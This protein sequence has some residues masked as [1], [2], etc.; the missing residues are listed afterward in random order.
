MNNY[1][2]II[3]SIS[4]IIMTAFAVT[5]ATNYPVNIDGLK[6]ADKVPLTKNALTGKLPNGLTYFI[7]E[8]TLPANR[9]HLALVV[10]AGSVLETEEQRGFAHFVEH[11]AFNDTARFPKLELI[12]YLR[13][14]G[15]RFGADANAYTSYDQTVYHFDVPVEI[16]GGVKRIPDKALAILDDWTYAVSF[17]PEDVK[18][19]SLVV[20]EEFRTGLGAMERV[21]KKLL[22]VLFSG[23]PYADRQPIGLEETVANA[24]SDQLRA[25]YDRWY[26][27]DNMALV[28][29]GDFD[30]KTLEAELVKHFNM[31]SAE[32]PVKRPRYELPPPK[33]NNFQVEILTDP[34]LA[35]SSINIYFKQKKGAKPGTIGSYYEN[36]IDNLIE[37][38]LAFR[39]EEI[40]SNPD[41]S[42]AELWGYIWNSFENSN[43]FAMGTQPKGSNY[44]N[45]LKEILLEKESMRRFGFTESELKRAKL[46][47]LSNMEKQL[48]EKDRIESRSFISGFT[49]YFVYGRDMADIE[50]EVNASNILIE[51]ITLKEISR[52][53]KNYFANNDC[54]VFLISP[55][56]EEANLPSKEK[57]KNIFLE[58][59]SAELLPRNDNILT[60]DLMDKVPAA[61]VIASET[62]DA[63]TGAYILT[64]ANGAKV[65]LKESA[66]KNNEIV[67]YAIARGGKTNAGIDAAASVSALSDMIDSSGLGP[68]SRTELISKLTGKQVFLSF[69]VSN[70]YRGFQGFSTT[71]DLKTFFEMIHLFFT[72][73]KLDERSISALL[74][75]YRANLAHQEENPERYFSNELTRIINNYNPYFM[76]LVLSDIDKISFKA[77]DDY[78]NRCV[79]PSD[80]T[81]VFTGN[82]SLDAMREFTSEYIAS[83]PVNRGR[84]SS[85][86]R[87]NNPGVSRPKA[88]KRIIKKGM[89]DRSIVYIGWFAKG[90]DAFSEKRN[91]TAAVLTE[92]LDILL[93]DEIREKLGGVYSISAGASVFSIPEGEYRLYAYFVCNPSRADELILAV[94]NSINNAAKQPLDM[95]KFKKSKEALLMEHESSLQRNMHIAQSYANSTAL[96]NT[97][98][99]RLNLR[100]DAIRAVTTQDVQALCREII[101]NGA[102]EVVLLPE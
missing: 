38:M 5:C 98:L 11:L 21:R 86:N 36:I 33:N 50:W 24:A 40:I 3:I 26:A 22:P 1:K 80:Y 27:S 69:W 6:S 2:K 85:I 77:A 57:I 84:V 95:D 91:Q 59:K 71:A 53:V 83:I 73:P 81:F 75:Q 13:S 46:S 9:A 76:P 89:D 39:F 101:A 61:G 87:W 28:F 51:K 30:G 20:L 97:P 23:S 31:P 35:Y 47:Y 14:L 17:L 62:R 74:D 16:S 65:I 68:Y 96:Y 25:F 37:T 102:V 92:Y 42:S 52:A 70:Y 19:E 58:T 49:G 88:G 41:S 43:F 45:A 48:S 82:L 4:F 99:N 29:A 44:V 90:E 67:M 8:N 34:E 55:Q 63:E 79:N 78:L 18:S 15:M 10:N 64:L 60:G 100:P 54:I 12:E 56:S 94:K 32:K 93:T 72:Q 7:L 66:N